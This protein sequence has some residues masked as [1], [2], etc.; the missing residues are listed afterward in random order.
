M[1]TPL[2]A[3]PPVA[4]YPANKRFTAFYPLL[5]FL[6]FSALFILLRSKDPLAV[7]GAFRCFDVFRQPQLSF[8]KNNHA[9]YPANVFIWTRIARFV[10]FNIT[11]A[12]KFLS[13][14]ELMNCL[15]AAGCLA[16]FFQLSYLATLSNKVALGVTFAFGFTRAF[17]IHAT[18]ASEPMVGV[19]WSFLGVYL[20]AR[21]F[22]THSRWPAFFSGLC[23]ALAITTYQ[24]T[25]LFGPIAALI[26]WAAARPR[27]PSD[28]NGLSEKLRNVSIFGAGALIGC[29]FIYGCI[30][31]FRIHSGAAGPTTAWT[32]S[33]L[34]KD[35]DTR[36]FF[37][38]SSG[39]ILN[40][41]LG[42]L[43]NCYPVLA[44]FAGLR[45]FLGGSVLSVS[46]I[47]LLLVAFAA[48]AVFC[49][50]RNAKLWKLCESRTR[51]AI[52]CGVVGLAFTAIPLFLWDPHYDKLWIQPLACVVF[53]LGMSF[54]AISSRL[55]HPFF[56]ARALPAVLLIGLL[57]NL[58][59]VGRSHTASITEMREA[60]RLSTLISRGDLL[61]GDWDGV[62]DLYHSAWLPANT[63]FISFPTDANLYGPQVIARLQQS[64]NTTLSAGH[65]VF[66]LGL[67]D[68]SKQSWDSFLGARCG[69]SYSS[70]ASYRAHAAPY[71]SFDTRYGAV[72]LKRLDVGS[73]PPPTK[74]ANQ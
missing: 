7:D 41:P 51:F 48:L 66:F 35:P 37:G 54:Q 34:L 70:I 44:S 47:F 49:V 24:S 43:R 58:V 25:V 31:H 36:A 40:L 21:C 50:V 52:L 63:Q 10:G 46:F 1:P 61:V 16:L 27:T 9:L 68:A 26:L 29:L 55:S 71:A 14:V 30:V 32:I 69:I 65:R 56:F 42:F 19:F 6:F 45:G 20:A 13:V 64:V 33:G 67:L 5:I 2:T 62:F 28:T 38:L 39:K 18:N 12:Q 17:L 22:K 23:F 11:S 3:A 57:S 73:Q 59:P 53:L 60:Q 72:K 4:I 8:T 74:L 15:A